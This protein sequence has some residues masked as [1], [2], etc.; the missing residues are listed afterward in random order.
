VGLGPGGAFQVFARLMFD[1]FFIT[2]NGK[3]ISQNRPREDL[4]STT[5]NRQR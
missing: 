2:N 4:E 3:K 1:V 5:P